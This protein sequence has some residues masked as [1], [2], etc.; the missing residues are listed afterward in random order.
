MNSFAEKLLSKL[1]H[2]I[3]L[4]RLFEVMERANIDED[5]FINTLLNYSANTKTSIQDIYWC[6]LLY[7]HILALVSKDIKKYFNLDVYDFVYIGYNYHSPKFCIN[8]SKTQEVIEI[9]LRLSK[10]VAWYDLS[11]ATQF[12]LVDLNINYYINEINK[13]KNR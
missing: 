2:P 5:E 1:Q 12:L 13:L 7:E 8:K 4:K 6:E 3:K 11:P 9:A 10:D